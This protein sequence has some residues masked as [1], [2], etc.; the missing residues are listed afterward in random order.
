MNKRTRLII[1]LALIAVCGAFI[2]PTIKWYFIVPAEDKVLAG[3]SREQVREYAQE[4]A[5]ADLKE[6]TA[7]I[8]QDTDGIVPE[9]FDYLK[10]KAEENYRYDEWEVPKEWTLQQLFKGYK[11]QTDM[12]IELENF[13]RQRIEDL[14]DLRDRSLQLGL[15]LSGGMSLV[16]QADMESLEQRLGHSPS[17]DDRNEAMERAMEILT[18]RIDQFGLTEPQIR[19]QGQGSDRILIDVPG[20]ADPE[21]ARSFL[22]GKGS[23]AF[24]LVD[25][26]GTQSLIE[27]QQANPGYSPNNPIFEVDF[28]QAGTKPAGYFTKDS[29]GV[30]KL[31]RYIV[32][33]EEAGLDGIH[34][35]EAQVDNDP[36]TGKPTVNFVLDKSGS[37]IFYLLTDENVGKSLAIVMD[38]KVKAYA[39]I[40]EAIPSGQVRITGFDQQEA[41]TLA[42]VLRTAAMPVDLVIM[43]QESIG[44]SLGED[45][46]RSGSQAILLGLILVVIFMVIYY[47]GAG[48]IADLALVL[49]L[50]IIISILSV[51][52]LTLT[53]TSIAGIILTVGMSVDA[54][55]IIFERIKE[56]YRIGKSPQAAVKAGFQ[57]AFWTVMDANITTFIAA[58]F[59]SQL[60]KGPI[61]GFAV[62]LAVGIVSSMFTA[63]F[64]SRLIFDFST[65]VLKRQKLSIAWR[66]K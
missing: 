51:F 25:D 58:I 27:Y 57:K 39:R 17:A 28:I 3:G 60:G 4:K 45:S 15:D 1:I 6:M 49:N 19:R 9:K 42:L 55:V 41:D 53:L 22:M 32:I 46:I 62:T 37:D 11:N 65:G 26:E 2:Y 64:V 54:N 21:T 38:N 24:H 63:L 29:Y 47:K 33:L 5:V 14:Q 59:L 36:I 23:L 31:V 20:E 50:F 66:T 18:N 56:E 44:A 48:L 30:D 40:S 12:Y 13:Y 35:R 43:N 8:Q 7:L 61:Q 34:I 16:L 10:T 52:H